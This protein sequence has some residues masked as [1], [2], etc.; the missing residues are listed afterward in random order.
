MVSFY[1]QEQV[2]SS[3][4]KLTIQIDMT[5]SEAT[6]KMLRKGEVKEATRRGLLI[7]IHQPSIYDC[8]DIVF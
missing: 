8:A 1:W 2:I 3:F 4:E 5:K 7:R 6:S